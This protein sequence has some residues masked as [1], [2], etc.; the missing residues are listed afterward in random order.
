MGWEYRVDIEK[1]SAYECNV[2]WETL[3]WNIHLEIEEKNKVG[4]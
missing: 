4:V 3:R 2:L 1:T